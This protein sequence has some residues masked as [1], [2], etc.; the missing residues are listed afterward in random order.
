MTATVDTPQTLYGRGRIYPMDA[1]TRLLMQF[2]AGAFLVFA[3]GFAGYGLFGAV[4]NAD[5]ITAE[6]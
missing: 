6:I 5:R 1:G 2:C 3:G 4:S